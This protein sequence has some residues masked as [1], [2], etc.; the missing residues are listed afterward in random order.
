MLKFYYTTSASDIFIRI[1]FPLKSS[2]K[3]VSGHWTKFGKFLTITVA[4]FNTSR[5]LNILFFEITKSF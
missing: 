4:Y 3:L 1:V 5:Y 2:V